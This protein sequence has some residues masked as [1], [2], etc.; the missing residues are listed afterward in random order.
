MK[1]Q[2]SAQIADAVTIVHFEETLFVCLR[3]IFNQKKHPCKK[4]LGSGTQIVKNAAL[5]L[6]SKTDPLRIYSMH[7]TSKVLREENQGFK[8]ETLKG[9]QSSNK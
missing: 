9:L 4:N 1:T 5:R 3:F 6:H 7:N 2:E 8:N